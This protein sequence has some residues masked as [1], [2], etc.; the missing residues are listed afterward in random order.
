L[1]AANGFR[2]QG[3]AIKEELLFSTS[4]ILES[5]IL[6]GREAGSWEEKWKKLPS[7]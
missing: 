1:A 3:E 6:F 7:I 5:P 4:R 2:I